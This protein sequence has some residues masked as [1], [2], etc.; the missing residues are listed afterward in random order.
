MSRWPLFKPLSKLL[1]CSYKDAGRFGSN[2]FTPCGQW[3]PLAKPIH[4]FAWPHASQ[5]AE[6]AESKSHGVG[7]CDEFPQRVHRSQHASGNGRWVCR[8]QRVGRDPR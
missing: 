6:V 3:H 5:P 7:P 4:D 1:A 2:S 8:R